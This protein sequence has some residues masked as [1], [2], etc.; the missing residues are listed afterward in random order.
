MLPVMWSLTI[1]ILRKVLRL[2]GAGARRGRSLPEQPVPETIDGAQLGETERDVMAKY[3]GGAD[4]YVSDGEDGE[5][6]ESEGE[7]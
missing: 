6:A 4:E 5:G 3:G 7:E 1:L 2:G